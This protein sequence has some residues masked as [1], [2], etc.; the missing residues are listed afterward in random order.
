MVENGKI[1][2]LQVVY[3]PGTTMESRQPPVSGNVRAQGPWNTLNWKAPICIKL[4]YESEDCSLASHVMAN[5]DTNS[6]A[7]RLGVRNLL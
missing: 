4:G 5:T 1:S 3:L 2:A 6:E 7:L